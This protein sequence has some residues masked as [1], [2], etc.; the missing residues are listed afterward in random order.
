MTRLAIIGAGAW[1]TALA[2]AARRAGSDATIWARDP[3]IAAAIRGA[4]TSPSHRSTNARYTVPVP[5][6]T[7]TPRA[8]KPRSLP[9]FLRIIE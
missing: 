3:A 6:T 8:N 1:G 4:L 9:R 7:N 5:T 2:L